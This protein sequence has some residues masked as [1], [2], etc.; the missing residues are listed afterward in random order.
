METERRLVFYKSKL[1]SDCDFFLF[2]SFE[3]YCGEQLLKMGILSLN[4]W[5]DKIFPL[6][7]WCNR[8]SLT[9]LHFI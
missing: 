5:N 9:C 4:Y 8:D 6:F 3:S 2:F 7:L 1:E